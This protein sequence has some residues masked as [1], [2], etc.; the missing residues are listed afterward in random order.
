MKKFLVFLAFSLP[1]AVLA[2]DYQSTL[3]VQ[4]GKLRESDLIVRTITDLESNRI[5]LAFYVQTTGTS[6][7][8]RNR[9]LTVKYVETANTS[10]SSGDLKFTQSCR[11]LGY[12]KSQ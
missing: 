7:V 5:C 4:T 8:M 9:V 3:L 10:H 11:W 2:E 6:P 1:L 12:G